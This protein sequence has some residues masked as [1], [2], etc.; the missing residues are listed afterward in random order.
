[1]LAMIIIQK[2]MRR[3]LYRAV[4]VEE[5]SDAIGRLGQQLWIMAGEFSQKVCVVL[6]LRTKQELY[7]P[8]LPLWGISIDQIKDAA[9]NWK[10][11]V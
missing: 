9:M 6:A 4:A 8:G 7:N 11:Y 5:Q 10:V 1:M 3:P 2:K